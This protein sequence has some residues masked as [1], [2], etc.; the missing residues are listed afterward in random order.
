MILTAGQGDSSGH[1]RHVHRRIARRTRVCAWD[2]AGFGFS[3]PSSLPQDATHTT[4]DLEQALGGAGLN[5]PYVLVGHSAGSYET[6]LFADR[7]DRAVSGMVLVDPS[8]PDQ[9]RAIA[10]EAPR[11]S[12]YLDSEDAASVAHERAC[13]QLLRQRVVTLDSNDPT[14]CLDYPLSYPLALKQAL[15]GLAADDARERT[16]ASLVEHFAASAQ[17][18]VKQGR[19]YGGRPLIVLTA[20][21]HELPS[22][23]PADVVAEM[24]AFET[25]WKN[26]H[27]SMAAL[28]SAGV[29]RVIASSGHYIQTDQ[30]G[31]VVTAVEDVVRQIR[32]AAK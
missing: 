16:Q 31:V 13:G 1:W 26:A 22:D 3:D 7:N 15:I 18:V 9:R 28:S 2:R 10:R 19:E 25:F 32:T 30:P 8:I 27:E 14:H 21:T 20:A 5:G 29:H 12:K 17:L 11:F 23:A 6:L 4:S 24:P